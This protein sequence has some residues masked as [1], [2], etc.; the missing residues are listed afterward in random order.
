MQRYLKFIIALLAPLAVGAVSGWVTVES[1]NG[2]FATINKPPFNP[3]NEVFAPVWSTLYILMGIS[4]FIVWKSDA[5]KDDKRQAFIFYFVQLLLNFAWSFIFFEFHEIGWAFI[6]I[7]LL[8]LMIMFTI[9]SFAN[10]SRI[11]A[12]LLIPYICWVGY[13]GV[14]NYFIWRLN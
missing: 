9:I 8:W 11:A 7:I 6:D 2:W 10:I 13:A 14:L 3:P 4:F 5:A 1:V 12:V